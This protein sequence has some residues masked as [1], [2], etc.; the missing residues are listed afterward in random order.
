[1]PVNHTLGFGARQNY[2][3]ARLARPSFVNVF[4]G[5]LNSFV[6]DNDLGDG[7]YVGE[8]ATL[9]SQRA[10]REL[11]REHGLATRQIGASCREAGQVR[12]LVGL[13]V[14]TIPPKVARAFLDLGLSPDE[15]ADRTGE[16]YEPPL[17]DGVDAA[18]VG[19]P[20]LWNV[21]ERLKECVE[22][23]LVEDLDG[24]DAERLLDF[25]ADRDCADVLTRWSEDDV[26]TS[27]EEGKMPALENWRDLLANGAV[28]LDGLMNLAG[29][30]SFA[31]DQEEMD[32]RVRE[33][34]G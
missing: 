24:F 1:V 26:R 33:V 2:L 19:L 14:M 8:K 13:D 25:F 21:D 16:Q 4:M 3:V 27:A 34:A 10:V 18:A 17:N 22:R 12:D 15:L 32:R 7:T 9:A 23:L 28:G 31:A 30:N 20:T 5:R 29:W 6:A 11:R